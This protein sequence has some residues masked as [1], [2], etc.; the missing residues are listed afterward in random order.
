ML[1]AFY[2]HDYCDSK[3]ARF[4]MKKKNLTNNKKT[5]IKQTCRNNFA[6]IFYL[7]I[8]NLHELFSFYHR[9]SLRAITLRFQIL[10]SLT[11]RQ[12]APLTKIQYQIQDL[13]EHLK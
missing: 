12:R 1:H 8:N 5:R 9:H 7:S 4:G 3:K 10:Q 11:S 2:L 13:S 6:M